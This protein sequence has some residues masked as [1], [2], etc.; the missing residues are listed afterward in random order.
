MP[1][2]RPSGCRGTKLPAIP[3]PPSLAVLSRFSPSWPASMPAHG[4]PWCDKLISPCSAVADRG[5]LAYGLTGAAMGLLVG[6]F[7]TRW[8]SRWCGWWVGAAGERWGAEGDDGGA[9]WT[10]T[11]RDYHEKNGPTRCEK[12]GNAL[13]SEKI[14]NLC[15][16]SQIF[17]FFVFKH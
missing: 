9:V 17:M 2:A 14:M 12:R 4:S 15:L 8:L 13:I 16:S 3:P 5:T 1:V 11:T 7:R 10:R 6:A